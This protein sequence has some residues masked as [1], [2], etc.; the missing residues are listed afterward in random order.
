MLFRGT[1]SIGQALRAQ[2]AFSIVDD[3]NIK[4]AADHEVLDHQ[5][6]IELLVSIDPETCVIKAEL[7][8]HLAPVEANLM[9]LAVVAIVLRQEILVSQVTA[10]L[11]LG[12]DELYVAVNEPD[13]GAQ[14][15]M[16]R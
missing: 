12:S 16:P 6:C 15:G 4:P 10:R 14:P 1:G 3:W 11:T 8:K 5:A 7:L 9:A 13:T 2:T